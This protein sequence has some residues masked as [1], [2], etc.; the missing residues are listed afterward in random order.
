LWLWLEFYENEVDLLKD[1]QVVQVVL[2]AIP[3]RML[4]GKI[5]AISPVVKPV[6]RTAKVR[7]DIANA[8][9]RLKPGIYAEVVADIDAGDKLTIPA[10]AVLPTGSRMLVFVA[11]GSGRLEPRYVDLG[12]QFVD[13]NGRTGEPYYEVMS[14]LVDGEWVVA[15]ANFLIDSEAQIQGAIKDFQ[16][17]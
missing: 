9:G 7:V 1:G 4:T 6:T 5:K 11:R 14:G 2:P 15:S 12:T 13:A 10:E 16:G 17:E 3:G 8:D